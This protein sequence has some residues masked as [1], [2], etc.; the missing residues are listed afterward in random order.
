MTTKDNGPN[1]NSDNQEKL[2]VRPP[3]NERAPTGPIGLDIN[4]ETPE[5]IGISIVAELIQKKRAR[6]H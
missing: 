2:E 6:E 4:A 1:E 3:L 5:E